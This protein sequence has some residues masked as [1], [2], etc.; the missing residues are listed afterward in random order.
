MLETNYRSPATIVEA[1]AALIA[2]N[3]GQIPRQVVVSSQERGEAFIHEVPDDDSAIINK[4][5]QLVNEERKRV[6]PDQILVLSRTNH[7][8]D[9]IREGC[10]RGGIKVANPFRDSSGVPILSAHKARGLEAN[11]GGIANG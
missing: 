5:V 11:V 9:A 6:D 1:G 7:L 3:P 2:H 10:Q 4:A 8:N